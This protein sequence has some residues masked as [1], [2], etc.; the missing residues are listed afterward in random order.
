MCISMALILDLRRLPTVQEQHPRDYA[1]QSRRYKVP[2]WMP[3]LHSPYYDYL[4]LANYYNGRV[5][6]SYHPIRVSD[7]KITPQV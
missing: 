3:P 7:M 5:S 2:A 6:P 4:V 1:I